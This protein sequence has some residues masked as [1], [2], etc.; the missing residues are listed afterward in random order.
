MER[1]TDNR[2]HTSTQCN[3]DWSCLCTMQFLHHS[4]PS[5]QSLQRYDRKG[6]LQ[7]AQPLVNFLRPSKTMHSSRYSS[8]YS[9]HVARGT[10]W[11]FN[12]EI[13]KLWR[14]PNCNMPSS[15]NISP[16]VS[17]LSGYLEVLW[18]A[19]G[20]RWKVCSRPLGYHPHQYPYHYCC[21]HPGTRLKDQ[22]APVRW[23]YNDNSHID[24]QTSQ[25]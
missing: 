7:P 20:S 14:D 24:G 13:C 22:L 9:I 1:K 25:K 21:W 3:G 6:L 4:G 2:P 12:H 5:L 17:R 10:S 16:V 15:G 11:T 8:L 18:F 19:L 23:N